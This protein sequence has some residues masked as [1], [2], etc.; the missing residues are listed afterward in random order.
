[1]NVRPIAGLLFLGLVA[2]AGVLTARQAPASASPDYSKEI[3]AAR[4]AAFQSYEHGFAVPNGTLYRPPAFSWA[5]AVDGK[6]VAADA[7]GFGDLEERLPATTETKF[8]I[9]SVSKTLT[10]AGLAVL[11]EQGKLDLDVPIQRYVP[12]FPDKGAAIT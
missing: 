11:Y 12:K 10:S 8:R 5:I 1:M 4:E 7:Y 9:G 3:A 2:S 6:L